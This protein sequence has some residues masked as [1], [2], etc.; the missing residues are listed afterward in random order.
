[1]GRNGGGSSTSLAPGFRF[2][3]TDEELVAYYLKR[4]VSGKSF[5]V[6]AISEIE[7]YKVEPWDLPGL[8]RLKTRDLEWYFFSNLD[9][10]YSN[11]SKTNRATSEGYWKTTGKDRPVC[12]RS[13]VVGMKKTLVFHRGRAPRG[14]RT[15]WV[16]HEYRLVDEQLEQSGVPQESFVLCRIFQKSGSG[17]KNGERYGAPLI[18]EEW[19]GEGVEVDILHGEPDV[20]EVFITDELFTEGNDYDQNFSVEL[21][22]EN[23]NPLLN[24]Y[25]GDG[26]SFVE[27]L[28]ENELESLPLVNEDQLGLETYDDQKFFNLP[29][30]HELEAV[31]NEYAAPP[32]N[33][34]SHVPSNNLPGEMCLD[35]VNLASSDEGFYLETNDLSEPIE[36]KSSGLQ[37]LDEYLTYFD[38]END[39]TQYLTFDEPESLV[40][41]DNSSDQTSLPDQ[42]LDQVIELASTSN[43]QLPAPEAFGAESASSSKQVMEAQKFEPDFKYPFLKQES[44][45]LDNCSAFASDFPTKDVAAKL[46]GAVHS[47]ES[48]RVTA[49]MVRIRDL[50]INDNGIHWSLDKRGNVNVVL[51]F[52]LP[53]GIFVNPAGMKA[54]TGMIS[55]KMTSVISRDWAYFFFSVMLVFMSAKVGSCIYAR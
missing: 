42:N 47:S 15:N 50:S 5:R 17:P 53:E 41:N 1:M 22:V 20:N 24:S 26:S 14:E 45:M 55:Q 32:A 18:E 27:D 4:K 39:I 30:Q 54:L 19:E 21:P 16:M 12:H 11:G 9:K 46:R 23:P 49:G 10:K 6:D 31:K 25:Q 37:L 38:A 48:I 8:S 40:A 3:P 28:A 13:K 52:D 29:V 7:V 51:S 34:M 44:Q 2:H 33:V 43:Q 35:N 36:A